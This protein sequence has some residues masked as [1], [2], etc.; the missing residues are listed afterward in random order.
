MI[1]LHNTSA[2]ETVT[3][4]LLSLEKLKGYSAFVILEIL[5]VSD[6]DLNGTTLTLGPQT[7]VILQ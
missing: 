4:D 5:G 7:S 3:V 6:A 1:I 2:T